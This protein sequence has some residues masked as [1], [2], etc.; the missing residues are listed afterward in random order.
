[1]SKQTC[2]FLR[3]CT[4]RTP[5]VLWVSVAANSF[6]NLTTRIDS[7]DR[8]QM[9][10]IVVR[11]KDLQKSWNRGFRYPDM[12]NDFHH[13]LAQSTGNGMTVRQNGIADHKIQW[14]ELLARSE[15]PPAGAENTLK[16]L[17]TICLSKLF[18]CWDH[19][20]F[21]KNK[22]HV[23]NPLGASKFRRCKSI[24]QFDHTDWQQRPENC[25]TYS[26]IIRIYKFHE[27]GEFRYPGFQNDFEYELAQLLEDGMFRRQNRFTS[28][29]IQWKDA[30][31]HSERP[32]AE[33]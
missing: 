14:K 4:C 20:F 26:K 24:F 2:Q 28:P 31:A 23:T 6:F 30:P 27:I 15:R 32:P 5:L 33:P 19:F 21:Q 22:C 9:R 8:K 1:M 7:D 3:S 11:L 17:E 10:K 16:C 12:Q 13:E 29:I 18:N 25:E